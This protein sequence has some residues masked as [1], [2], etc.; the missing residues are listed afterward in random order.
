METGSLN[1]FYLKKKVL[2]P[3]CSVTVRMRISRH[4]LS[5]KQG[6]QII[7]F[8]LRNITDL[9]RIKKR[10]STLAEIVS[11][12]KENKSIRFQLK[13]LK[14]TKV[15]DL[16]H[17]HLAQYIIIPE[18]PAQQDSTLAKELRKKAQELIFLINVEESDRLI[19]LMNFLIDLGQITDFISNYFVL[20]DKIRNELLNETDISERSRLLQ[21]K[22]QQIIKNIG[23]ED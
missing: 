8:P 20:D 9:F 19:E 3:H 14:R 2:F 13:G 11:I 4:T 16:Q 5:L 6:D 18:A 21:T 17:F 10:I 1:I 22:I 7:V 12:E 23:K 15:T